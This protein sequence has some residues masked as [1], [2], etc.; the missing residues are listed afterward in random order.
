MQVSMISFELFCLYQTD[1]QY[2]YR[3]G[4]PPLEIESFIIGVHVPTPI[5]SNFSCCI[6]WTQVQGASWRWAR[7][8]DWMTFASKLAGL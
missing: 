1:I 7:K 6:A 3:I 2:K 8:I 5:T 4:M